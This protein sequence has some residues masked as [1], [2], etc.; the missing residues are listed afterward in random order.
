MIRRFL[1]LLR[2]F[3]FP[4]LGLTHEGQTLYRAPCASCHEASG[5]TRAPARE[6]LR[7]LTPERILD[8]LE[9]QSGAMRVQG[10]ARTPA[11]RR[12]LALFLSGK[13]FGTEKALD[14]TQASCKETQD[15]KSTRLNS[16]HI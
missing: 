15:R 9:A 11:E 14:L 4:A 16:S 7:Q 1:S 10:L 3:A 13:P 12:A 8:A 2:T 5:Q 6:A